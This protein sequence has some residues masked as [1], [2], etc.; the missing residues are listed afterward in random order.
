MLTPE[1]IAL[2]VTQQVRSRQADPGTVIVTLPFLDSLGDPIELDITEH[3]DQYVLSDRGAVAGI[4]FSS[5]ADHYT[6]PQHR[7]LTRLASAYGLTLDHDEG[8]VTA[9]TDVYHLQEDLGRLATAVTAMI[10]AAPLL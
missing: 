10:A 1:E 4:L 3:E 7:L 8:L 6:S 2:A 9:T 5:A